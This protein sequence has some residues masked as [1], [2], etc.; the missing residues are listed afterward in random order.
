MEASHDRVDLVCTG[1]F[2]RLFDRIDAFHGF[3]SSGDCGHGH[4]GSERNGKCQWRI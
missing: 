2:L 4:I 3:H 1:A